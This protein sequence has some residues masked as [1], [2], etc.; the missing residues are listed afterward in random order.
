M[1]ILKYKLTLSFYE[2]LIIIATYKFIKHERVLEKRRT[3]N[4]CLRKKSETYSKS[5]V[6]KMLS[7]KMSS[8]KRHPKTLSKKRGPKNNV[9]KNV[10]QKTSS[11]K[12]HLKHIIRKTSSE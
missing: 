2:G 11:K 7:K 1:T 8:K 3:K 9:L 12:R 5:V 10:V 6:Q 4:H